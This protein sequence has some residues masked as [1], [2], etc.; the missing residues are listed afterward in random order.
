[1][2]RNGISNRLNF[3]ILCFSCILLLSV[4]YLFLRRISICWKLRCRIFI[5]NR[6]NYLLSGASSIPYLLLPL[7]QQDRLRS[8]HNLRAARVRAKAISFF[9]DSVFTFKKLSMNLSSI[10]SSVFHNKPK[11]QVHQPCEGK[12]FASRALSPV[13]ERE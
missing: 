4:P 7:I 11:R 8:G 2:E 13:S 1:M 5:W 9:F 12:L 10:C 3:S 6:M